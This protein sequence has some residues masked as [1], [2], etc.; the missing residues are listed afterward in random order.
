MKLQTLKLRVQTLSGN[1]LRMAD[2]SGSWRAG[3]TSAER[4]YGYKWQQARAGYLRSH[5]LC[6]MCQADGVIEPA[7]VV[8]H[9]V[10]HE[11]DQALFWDKRNWQSLCATHHN[12]DKQRAERA[13]R[14][15]R[16]RSQR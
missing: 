14:A 9:I 4:G 1:R 3:K 11:G 7:T 8:D 2:Q 12:S 10:P 5:P 15:A 16:D 13:E 6:V